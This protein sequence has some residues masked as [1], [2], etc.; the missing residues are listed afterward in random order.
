MAVKAQKKVVATK[1]KASKTHSKKLVSLPKP[2]EV[3]VKEVMG[4]VFT[5]VLRRPR[6]G[7]Y[8]QIS[9][10]AVESD[11]D[12]NWLGVRKRLFHSDTYREIDSLRTEARIFV[13]SKSLPSILKKGMYMV[14]KEN[15]AMVQAKLDELKSKMDVLI[16]KFAH[17]E[18]ESVVEAA[19]KPLGSQWNRGDYLSKRDVE[20]R[21]N[22]S[23]RWLTYDIPVD[24]DADTY[25][26]QQEIAA[27]DWETAREV[28][29]GLLRN[30]FSEVVSHLVERL[31]PSKDG[32]K[33]VLRDS[34]VTNIS[35]WI[36]DFNPRN[37]ENDTQLKAL[38]DK[39]QLLVKGVNP[40]VLREDE[41][42]R[43][44]MRAHFE[45]IKNTL[46]SLVVTEG[47]REVSF[48]ED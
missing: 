8:R 7:V 23:W 28:W 6:L 31:K 26:E 46:E 18:W 32:K 29:K 20:Q 16:H 14:P 5:L 10:K 37:I 27:K 40:E 24:L 21:F 44:N 25:K 43:N 17:E 13:A 12:S 4:K 9:S 11:V 19:K 30:E 42:A 38:V 1:T 22:M 48:D 3:P 33:K 35:D 15:Q 45:T 2:K 41:T 36:N 47:S 34:A 39:A